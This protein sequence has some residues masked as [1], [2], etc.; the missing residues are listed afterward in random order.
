M[1]AGACRRCRETPGPG[2]RAGLPPPPPP[3]TSLAVVLE[4]ALEGAHHTCTGGMWLRA[5]QALAVV[6][7]TRGK[8]LEKLA[9]EM[10]AND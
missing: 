6:P 3:I 5:P 7:E 4:G 8:S 10:S 1:R 2:A 9:L